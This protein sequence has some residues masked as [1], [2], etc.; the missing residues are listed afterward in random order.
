MSFLFMKDIHLLTAVKE[1]IWQA[2]I[3]LLTY[4]TYFVRVE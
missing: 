1:W 4:R 3:L 2:V